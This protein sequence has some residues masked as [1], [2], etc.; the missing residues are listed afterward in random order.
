MTHSLSIPKPDRQFPIEKELF[1]ACLE[2]KPLAV[3]PPVKRFLHCGT[4][5]SA[6]F[7]HALAH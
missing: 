2:D 1:A 5:W 3:L 4:G 7:K 6:I